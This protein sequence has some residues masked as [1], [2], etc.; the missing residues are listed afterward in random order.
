MSAP[1]KTAKLG[2]AYNTKLS[3]LYQNEQLLFLFLK[4]IKVMYHRQQNKCYP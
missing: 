4:T 3:C 2:T 1:G